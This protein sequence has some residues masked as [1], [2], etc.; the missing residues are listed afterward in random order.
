M[1]RPGGLGK[2]TAA[3]IEK[4]A[5]S[6]GH[7][8]IIDVMPVDVISFAST[9][10]KS[11]ATIR[12][13]INSIQG[14]LNYMREGFDLQPMRVRKPADSDPKSSRFTTVQRERMLATAAAHYPWFVP[15]LA[16]LF[17]TGVRRSELCNLRWSDLEVDTMGN[18]VTIFVRSRKGSKGTVI[19]RRVPV[20]PFLQPILHAL[21]SRGT[22]HVFLSSIN[23]PIT[24][25]AS[26]NKVFAK[27]AEKAGIVDLTPHDTRRTFAS[28]L[29]E[30][31][32]PDL[33]ITDMLG[34]VDKKML[35]VYAVVSDNIR[36]NA[37]EKIASPTGVIA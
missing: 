5:S 28:E 9:P 4:F 25:P 37:V 27:V 30:N 10:G 16:F 26:I 22:E 23:K 36:R 7:L 1:R 20:H 19:T 14:F 24:S 29:L 31:D 15:H 12:R 32:V 2:T 17:Y 13:E 11:P 8:A 3:Y 18:F 6:N 21:K 33:L 34:H 35:K